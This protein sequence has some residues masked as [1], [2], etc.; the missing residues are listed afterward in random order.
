ML[1]DTTV[2][3]ELV[4]DPR[5]RDSNNTILHKTFAGG[6]NLEPTEENPWTD[7]DKDGELGISLDARLKKMKE[8]AEYIIAKRAKEEEIALQDRDKRIGGGD[9]ATQELNEVERGKDAENDED[10]FWAKEI[11]NRQ[12]DA[13]I[14][15]MKWRKKGAIS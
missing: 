6:E 5:A 7:V 10:K 11:E 8:S 4:K 14:A 1:R 15:V 12:E 3:K 9:D 2:L 13:R